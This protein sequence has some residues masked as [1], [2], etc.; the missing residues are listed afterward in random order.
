MLSFHGSE[1]FDR[2]LHYTVLAILGK[3]LEVEFI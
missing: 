1:I 2:A 3:K